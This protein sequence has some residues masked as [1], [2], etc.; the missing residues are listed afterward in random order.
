MAQRI[1]PLAAVALLGTLACGSPPR[2]SAP[3]PAS[4]GTAEEDSTAEDEKDAEGDEDIV[5]PPDS[6]EYAPLD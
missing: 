3:A 5:P 1:I 6:P 4:Q 2:S